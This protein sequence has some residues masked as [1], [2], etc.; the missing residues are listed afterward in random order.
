[1]V[2]Q[3]FGMPS[4]PVE[5]TLTM[6]QEMKFFLRTGFMDSTDF[7]SSNFEIKT[8]GHCQGN[9]ASPAG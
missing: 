8:Q 7:A 1:M 5:A 4:T 2:F 6:I 3:A 9:G